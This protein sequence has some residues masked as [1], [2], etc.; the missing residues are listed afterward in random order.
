MGSELAASHSAGL[1]IAITGSGGSGAVTTGLILLEAVAQAGYYGLLSRSAGPQIRGGESAAMLRFS[2]QPVDCPDDRFDFVLGLDWRNVERFAD[3][4]PLDG[5]SVIL[6]DPKSGEVPDVLLASGASV[7]QAPFAELASAVQGGRLNMAALG[8][9]GA[10]ISLPVEA[11]ESGVRRTLGDKGKAVVGAAL[12]C[13]RSAYKTASTAT[14]VAL[15]V[16]GTGRPRWNISGNEAAGLGALRGGVRFV[17]AYPITPATEVLEW[18]APRLE[19]LGG[20]L[21]QAEDELASINMIIGSSFGGVPSLTATSGPGL[22]LMV[23]GLGLA[24]A[25][26]TPVVVVN[27]MRGGPSTGI[28]TKSE[29]SDL[30]IALY[31]LHGD[32]PHLV[33]AALS[34]RDCAF[35]TQW[36]VALAERLQ[37]AAIV[38]SDQSLGQS[39]AITDP[40]AESAMA[41][42]RVACPVQG[43]EYLRYQL[44]DDNVS[45]ISTPGILGGMYTADGLEHNERGTPSSMAGDH[46]IQLEK[47]LRKLESFDFGDA[48]AEIGGRGELG[49]VTWGSAAG[50][51]FEAAAR[52]EAAGTGVRVIALRLIAP[53]QRAR[54]QQALEGVDQVWVVEQNQSAQLFRY[55]NA[56]RV[57]PAAARAFARPGPLPLRPGEILDTIA[58]ED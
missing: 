43:E 19:R 37:T 44:T 42:R 32:A 22:S 35:T 46:R 3:E 36:A 28:P 6:S 48:W 38:L 15:L 58:S 4:L 29:Q 34:I 13:I 33:L 30:N 49:I 56:E 27:V 8:T 51:V 16:S 7:H 12:A 41:Q 5:A 54:L 39:R 20:S 31:G 10:L 24:V 40:P 21:L 17:A 9:L 23:E 25:S 11:L 50:A 26:E 57:L 52:L 18:L 2:P 53:L 47:R 45:V 1:S 14:P 55:L